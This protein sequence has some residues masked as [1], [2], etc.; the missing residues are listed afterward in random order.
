MFT[1]KHGFEAT[2]ITLIDDTGAHLLDDV[3]S[4]TFAD[5]VTLK[6]WDPGRDRLHKI[7]F[8]ISQ[9]KDLAAVLDLPEGV[10]QRQEK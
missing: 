6:Q 7:K 10:Y 8:S 5:C 1:I 4:N 2:T 9:A 3:T